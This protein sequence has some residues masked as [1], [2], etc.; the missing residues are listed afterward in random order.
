VGKCLKPTL[1]R[2]RKRT[3]WREGLT[4]RGEKQEKERGQSEHRQGASEI[5]GKKKRFVEENTERISSLRIGVGRFPKEILIWLWRRTG[6]ITTKK[7]GIGGSEGGK[8]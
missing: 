2:S 1:G 6:D 4:K 5:T 8:D 3:R 7:R